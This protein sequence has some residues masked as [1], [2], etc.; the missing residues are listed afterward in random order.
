MPGTHPNFSP[1]PFGR[2]RHISHRDAAFESALA[3]WCR[4]R[5]GSLARGELA[6]LMGMP[7]HA[8]IVG[9]RGHRGAEPSTTALTMVDPDA[10]VAE[11]R[12]HGQ[13][14]QAIGPSLAVR[15]L[16]QRVLGG[17][18]ELAAPRP[19]TRV[20]H[21]LWSLA[22]AAALADL[23]IDAEVWPAVAAPSGDRIVVELRVELGGKPATVIALCPS[24]LALASP[25]RAPLPRWPLDLAVVVARSTIPRGYVRVLRVNDIVTVERALELVL[26]E[27]RIGLSAAPRAMEATVTTGYV[28]RDMA[29]PDDAHLEMTVE[30]GKVRL[31]LQQLADLAP[32][33]IIP[34]GRPLAGPYEVRAG[35][36]LMGHGELVDVEGELG[37]RIV[38]LVEE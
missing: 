22:V 14:I 1:F 37:V 31:S 11:V 18:D 36:R 10:A 20:E 19:L 21:A 3:R 16:A 26:G 34:L 6:R 28:P 2:L 4:A 17:P 24:G 12:V 5:G 38:S 7:V 35:G 23:G 9:T 29:L 32:G 15:Q 13:A 25:P 8:Q 30:L 27:S 33:Q